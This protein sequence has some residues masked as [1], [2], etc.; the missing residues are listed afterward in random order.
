[1]PGFEGAPENWLGVFDSY[2]TVPTYYSII[3]PTGVVRVIITPEVHTVL[4]NLRELAQ[5]RSAA[6]GKHRARLPTQRAEVSL[7]PT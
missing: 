2:R 5:L 4:S 6:G 3:T 1:M 7:S